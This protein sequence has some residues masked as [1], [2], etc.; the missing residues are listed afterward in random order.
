[1]GLVKSRQKVLLACVA[2]VA[3]GGALAQDAVD[4]SNASQK[5]GRVTQLERIVVGAGVEKV[6]ID[7]PQSVSVI[8]QQ[9]ID[10][11]QPETVGD[12][13]RN[14]PGVNT[15]G[16]D[17]MFGQSF[18]IRGIGAPE[19]AGEE[20]RI[21]VNVDGVSKF[22]EQYRLG[23]FF[24]DPELYKQVEVLRGPAS[25]TLYGS[26]ALGGVINFATKDASDFLEGDEQGALKLKSTYSSNGNAI[27]E[28]FVLVQKISPD[29]DVLFSGN[30]R[31]AN[32]YHTG[33]GTVVRSS[34]YNTW[35][36]LAKVTANVGDEGKLGVSY[37]HWD[38]DA[39]DQDYAQTGTSESF[40]TVDRHIIDD[41]FI[42]SYE[43]PFT[44]SD[45]LDLKVSAS[46]SNT[47]NKQRDASGNPTARLTC[48]TSTLFCDSDYGYKAF[49]LNIQNTSETH[50]DG[51]DN[52]LTYGWQ[53]AHQTRTAD[54]LTSTSGVNFHPEGTDLR[55]GIFVQNEFVWNDVFTVIPGARFDWRTLSPA[56][57]T[58]LKSDFND[59]AFSP[60]IAA[61]YKITDNFALFGS[62]AHTERFPT[63][64]EVFSTGASRSTFDPSLGLKKEKSDNWELGFALS[65][66][67]L[68]QTND[69]AQLKTTFFHN[70]VKNLIALNPAL[71]SG[72]NRGVQGYVNLDRARF[73]GIEV[74]AAYDS[75]YVFASAAYTHIIG[76]NLSDNSFLPS[77]APDE[78]A[79]T[80]GGRVP[81]YDLEFG[82]KS[83]FIAG[84]Q[85]ACRNATTTVSCT[86][87]SS[88]RFSRPFNTQDIFLTWTP[89]QGQM[90]GWQ[91]QF[92]IDNVFNQNYKEF[93]NNDYSK[94][95]TFK[96]SLSKK[97]GW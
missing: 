6:A 77:V 33:D 16:S 25:S 68:L 39:N 81:D 97:F 47:L 48:A 54:I 44:D 94:G 7:T 2:F 27:L 91:A 92:G 86:G 73:Y 11:I 74:E 82:I 95:R 8:D 24:S 61:H 50:G 32:N 17:R 57:S 13:I 72:Y 1:M 26:G 64:D 43:N 20:G 80:L 41:T 23:S 9:E 67:D 58:G 38:S 53:F 56:S 19:S 45:L 28:N 60:K 35:S 62:F 85:D 46:Y 12:I 15:S 21:I 31:K 96:V 14:I 70:N 89:S 55:N 42:V 51:W 3:A 75:D 71:K 83:R 37:Q 30:Y 34:F 76:K 5:K 69:S 52:Y 66:N 4:N 59:T 36:G 90:K 29:V 93:L 88:S 84:P 65:G 63:I 10:T 87:G 40:G 79:L 22:Y 18:N 78:L 49:Q